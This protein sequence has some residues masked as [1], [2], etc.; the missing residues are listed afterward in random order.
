[1]TH[2]HF[3]AQTYPANQESVNEAILSEPNPGDDGWSPW[4]WLRLANGDLIL[5]RFPQGDT[6]FEQE[7]PSDEDYVRAEKAGH[8]EGGVMTINNNYDGD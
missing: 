3:L 6:Y 7:G 8:N 2:E 5:G 1:M 4:V